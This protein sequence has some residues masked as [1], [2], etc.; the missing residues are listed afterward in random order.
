MIESNVIYR[1]PR[2]NYAASFFTPGVYQ[3]KKWLPGFRQEYRPITFGQY[4]YYGIKGRLNH[5]F[6]HQQNQNSIISDSHKTSDTIIN[7]QN[8][9]KQTNLDAVI[10]NYNKT[11]RET[12]WTKT[13]QRLKSFIN[14]FVEKGS[15]I[16]FFEMP[17]EQLLLES[18]LNTYIRK[19]LANS[20]PNQSFIKA[21]D[22][23]TTDGVHLKPEEAHNYL[24]ELLIKI[25][26]L[27]P[28]Q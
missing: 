9:T 12:D 24:G 27:K 11:F 13:N 22:M 6:Q 7:T 18:E 16:C 20:Y 21:H 10:Q 26:Q 28:S 1:E 5:F 23:E 17:S 8:T 25:Y 15:T 2:Q 19:I 3:L 4:L 14:H